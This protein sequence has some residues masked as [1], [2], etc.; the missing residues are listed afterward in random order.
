MKGIISI[1]RGQPKYVKMIVGHSRSQL[2]I[3][4]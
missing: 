4:K 1:N 3:G 2:E